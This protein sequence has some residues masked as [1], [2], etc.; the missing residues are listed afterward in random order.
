[1]ARRRSGGRSRSGSRSVSSSSSLRNPP[2]TVKSAPPPAP[3]QGNSGSFLGAIADGIGW[4]AGSSIGHRA[5][6]AIFGPR[7][8][9]HETVASPAP[10]TVTP[11]AAPNAN[12]FGN[13]EACGGQSKAL[14]DCLNSYGSDISK[15][16]IYMDMLK[17]CRK[18][19]GV[20]LSA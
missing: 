2:Q 16:Q 11:A 4:G 6:D 18:S 12:S 9:K 5:V 1:M 10:E 20:E 17:E 14:T 8:V 19:S 7:V 15:C 3:V 13:S